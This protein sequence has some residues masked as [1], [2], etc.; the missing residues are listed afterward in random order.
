MASRLDSSEDE[1]MHLLEV[2]DAIRG[3]AMQMELS[4]G[5]DLWS[6]ILKQIRRTKYFDQRY[7]DAIEELIGSIVKGLDD[8]TVIAM[9]RETETGMAD[10]AEDEDLFPGSVRMDLEME[11]LDEIGKLAYE[12]AN[13]GHGA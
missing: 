4:E 7:A 11:L 8:A 12:E 2:L 3:K 6:A 5:A 10:N 1:T 9:W 13:V